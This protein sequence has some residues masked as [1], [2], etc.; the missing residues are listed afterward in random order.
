[1]DSS[2]RAL[3]AVELQFTAFLEETFGHAERVSE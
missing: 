2:R 3:V 1:V